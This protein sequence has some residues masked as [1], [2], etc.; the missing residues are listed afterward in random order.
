L[1]GKL[2]ERREGAV[3]VLGGRLF[4]ESRA[5]QLPRE[6]CKLILSSPEP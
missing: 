1:A 4:S 6:K 2:V 5:R 3:Y